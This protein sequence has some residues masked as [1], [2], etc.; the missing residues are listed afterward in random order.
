MI[1]PAFANDDGYHIPSIYWSKL[2]NRATN[3][4]LQSQKPLSCVE[5]NLYSYSLNTFS[6]DPRHAT[7]HATKCQSGNEPVEM[8]KNV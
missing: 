8:E 3:T 1:K 2:K 7:A 4:E 6:I 5:G